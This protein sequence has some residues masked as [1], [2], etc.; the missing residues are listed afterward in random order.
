ML[1]DLWTVTILPFLGRFIWWFIAVPIGGLLLY[2]LVTYAIDWLNR[3]GPGTVDNNTT[4]PI[5]TGNMG[6]D[7]ARIQKYIDCLRIAVMIDDK[8]QR[9]TKFKLECEKL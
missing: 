7:R 9:I 2:F 6:A 1:K 5:I 4:H 3:P 8:A